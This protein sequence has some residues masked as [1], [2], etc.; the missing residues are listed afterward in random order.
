MEGAGASIM[1]EATAK[2]VNA[3]YDCSRH[4]VYTGKKLVDLINM[5]DRVSNQ[6]TQCVSSPQ[7]DLEH[8]VMGTVLTPDTVSIHFTHYSPSLTGYL[9][10]VWAAVKLSF[11][12]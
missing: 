4:A 3:H 5:I 9:L 10:F 7:V 12:M 8:M 11:M 2:E 6:L 1:V